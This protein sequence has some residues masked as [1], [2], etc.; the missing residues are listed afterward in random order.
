M[1][2]GATNPSPLLQPHAGAEGGCGHPDEILTFRQR[3]LAKKSLR[4]NR[5]PKNDFGMKFGYLVF[6][7]KK[8]LISQ[9]KKH[10][11]P[12]SQFRLRK[13][14]QRSGAY[15]HHGQDIFQH[16]AFDPTG[17]ERNRFF[18]AFLVKICPVFLKNLFVYQIPE[19]FENEIRRGIALNMSQL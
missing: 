6:F 14:L 13:D 3:I 5:F 10:I 11:S 15:L 16:E 19:H 2:H 7:L 18:G 17:F 1:P 8:K 12:V 9:L 4:K